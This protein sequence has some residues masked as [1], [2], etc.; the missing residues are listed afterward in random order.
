MFYK[1]TSAEV[2]HQNFK[3]KT[4]NTYNAEIQDLN[5]TLI[6]EL[7]KAIALPQA[8]WAHFAFFEHLPQINLAPRV[9]FGELITGTHEHMLTEIEYAACR[10]RAK[11]MTWAHV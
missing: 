2:L 6:Y 10:T 5:Q 1:I 3:A 4:M 9:T 11:H 8:K 7:T